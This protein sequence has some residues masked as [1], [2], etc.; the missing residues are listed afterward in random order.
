MADTEGTP[1]N[2]VAQSGIITFNLEDYR[3]AG[4]RVVIDIKDQLYMGVMLKEKEFRQWVKEHDWEQYRD[5]YVAITC[6]EDAIVPAWAYMLVATK[7]Q[8]VAQFVYFGT[9]QELEDE[10][11]K[12][13]LD[14]V[15]FSQ[16]Q[17]AKIVAKGCGEITERIYVELTK[18]LMPYVGKLMYGEPCSMVPLYKSPNVAKKT[19][20]RSAKAASAN[21]G[22]G[23][24][25]G[26]A[27]SART[28]YTAEEAAAEKEESEREAAAQGY[29]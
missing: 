21:G 9:E 7:V 22:K 24:D 29:Q 25:A 10:L 17:D 20:R 28:D 13:E 15:D 19:S 6:S 27:E 2:R 8:P 16:Y 26:S 3:P 14:K 11:I 18:R 23:H 5:K 1:K 12:R 4:E